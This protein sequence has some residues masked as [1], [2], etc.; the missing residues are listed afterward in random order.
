MI[1]QTAAATPPGRLEAA[2]ARAIATVFG[3]G[4]SRVAPGTL[5]TA[6]AVP[7]AWAL[8]D[9]SVPTYLAVTAGVMLLIG[10]ILI[11]GALTFFPVLA[12]GPIV[13]H[14]VAQAGKV[15]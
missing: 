11:V 10:V 14:F 13:E 8:R 2:A 7:L 9:A 12:L 3:L 1:S 15:Y 4:Y 5:G 6:A